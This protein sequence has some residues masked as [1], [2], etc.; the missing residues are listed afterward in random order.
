MSAV[1]SL[2]IILQQMEELND[3]DPEYVLKSA[4][5]H[6]FFALYVCDLIELQITLNVKH[7]CCRAFVILLVMLSYAFTTT[8]FKLLY[9]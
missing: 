4:H 9:L 1:Q 6:F 3:Q 8:Q 5:L 2:Q 7:I